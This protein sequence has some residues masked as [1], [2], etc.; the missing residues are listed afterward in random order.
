MRELATSAENVL[1]PKGD[2]NKA[3]IEAFQ[4]FAD[5]E[6]PTFRGR[7]LV[8][9]SGGKVFWLMKGKDIPGLLA[10]GYGD[11][12][13]TGT[14]SRIEY[15]QNNSEPNQAVRYQRIGDEMCRFSLLS[16]TDEAEMMQYRLENSRSF[17]LLPVVTSKPTLLDYYTGNLPFIRKDVDI[18][19]SVEAALKLVG[20]ALAAD[21]VDTGN[22]ARENELTEIWTL[23]TMYPE[24]VARAES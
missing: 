13:V 1:I 2:D 8:A 24:I 7:E 23:G 12:G 4:A 20:A 3:C 16:L 9:R 19:G 11:V 15:N 18:N 10:S 6:I 14:D 21:I 5:I 17:Q 22:T